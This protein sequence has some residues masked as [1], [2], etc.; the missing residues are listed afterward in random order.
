MTPTDRIDEPFPGIRTWSAFSPGHRVD[1]GST[2]VL[3]A[4][5][6][7]IFDPIPISP[8]ASGTPFE[9]VAGI[10]LTNANHERDS[11]RWCDRLGCR[12]WAAPE[13]EGLPE[14][15]PRWTGSDPF[16]GW[17]LIPLVGGASGETAF[18]R[19]DRSL[20]VV[21]DALVNLPGRGLEVLPDKY[22]TDPLRLRRSLRRLPPVDLILPAHGAPIVSADFAALVR[23]WDVPGGG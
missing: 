8:T 5:G 1:L 18:L 22:C 10:L 21:G 9:R 12:R 4:E 20:M 15:I 13:A 11:A 3:T 17:I 7:W 16:P 6:W 23:T 2:A 19:T 14:G